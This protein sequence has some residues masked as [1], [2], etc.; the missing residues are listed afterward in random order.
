MSGALGTEL[1]PRWSLRIVSVPFGDGLLLH[2]EV[3]NQVHVLNATGALVWQACDGATPVSLVAEAFADA[4]GHPVD[5]VERDIRAHVA[6]LAAGQLVGRGEVP[7]HLALPEPGPVVGPLASRPLRVL[8]ERIVVR[9]DDPSVIAAVE[10]LFAD[11]LD[12][13]GSPGEPPKPAPQMVEIAE[14]AMASAP[15]GGYRLHGRGHDQTFVRLD[16]ALDVLPSLVNRLVAG[17]AAP[18]ALH[19]G[20]VRS[21]EGRVVVLAGASGTGKSTL[22]AAL[23]RAGWDYVTDEAAGIRP[24][25]LEVVGYPKPL[26]LDVTSRSVVGLPPGS[27]PVPV[28]ELRADALGACGDVGALAAVVLPAY[29]PGAAATASGP[30]A[31]DD[32]IAALAPHAINLVPSGAD[33]LATLAAIASRVPVHELAH[34]DLEQAV[35]LVRRLSLM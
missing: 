24:G 34:G 29:R 16:D 6:S 14:V 3:R 5:V 32:A 20:A 23:V 1:M 19:A 2:D 17:A 25:H 22:T 35:A 15:G 12:S 26:A 21:P 27:G 10:S 30:L 31:P 9:A 33:G 7:D 18:L 11:L 4:L 28:A 8:D 13:V